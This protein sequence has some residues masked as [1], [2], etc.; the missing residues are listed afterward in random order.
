MVLFVFA[1]VTR[2]GA[3]IEITQKEKMTVEGNVAARKG[4]VDWN[5]A[6]I[7]AMSLYDKYRSYI[8]AEF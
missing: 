4:G 7:I 1:V 3:W 2:K 6:V 5:S 8:K